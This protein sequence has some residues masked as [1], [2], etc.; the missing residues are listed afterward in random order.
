M[1]D[2]LPLDFLYHCDPDVRMQEIWDELGAL[3]EEIGDIRPLGEFRT[4]GRFFLWPRLH[5]S[6]IEPFVDNTGPE[7]WTVPDVPHVEVLFDP[8]EYLEAIRSSDDHHTEETTGR[9]VDLVTTMYETTE[10]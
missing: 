10:E 8:D 2:R 9:V 6:R 3:G 7:R 4:D 5:R 1:A